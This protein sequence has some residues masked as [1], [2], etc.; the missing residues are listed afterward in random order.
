MTKLLITRLAHFTNSIVFSS[1]KFKELM[2]KKRK[3]RYVNFTKKLID[4]LEGFSN[5][6]MNFFGMNYSMVFSDTLMF[7]IFRRDDW[8]AQSIY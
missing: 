2:K 7:W 6:Y 4:R 5:F 3:E 8:T 1:S